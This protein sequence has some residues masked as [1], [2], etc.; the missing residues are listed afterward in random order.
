MVAGADHQAWPGKTGMFDQVPGDAHAPGRVQGFVLGR[1]VE[2]AIHH[3]PVLAQGVEVPEK[4]LAEVFITLRRVHLDAGVEARDENDPLRE[5][6]A[7]SSR[8]GEAILG[9]EAVLVLA[10][11]GHV[12][13]GRV[14]G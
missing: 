13:R 5:L 12:F 6:P 4:A 7:P 1:S 2:A 11:K 3:P 8:D 14:E 10:A 9:I